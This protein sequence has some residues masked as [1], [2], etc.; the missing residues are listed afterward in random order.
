MPRRGDTHEVQL[1]PDKA[2]GRSLGL[3]GKLPLPPRGTRDTCT[4][5]ATFPAAKV[6][7]VLCKQNLPLTV[8]H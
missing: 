4:D 3:S 1:T 8:N 6:G 2:A 7:T 5:D